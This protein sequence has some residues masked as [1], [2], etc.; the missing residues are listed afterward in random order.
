MLKS[1]DVEENK[2]AQVSLTRTEVSG[3]KNLLEIL[4]HFEKL[5]EAEFRLA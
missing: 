3:A 4:N 1:G 5:L 2:E